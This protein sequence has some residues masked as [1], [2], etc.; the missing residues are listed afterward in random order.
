MGTMLELDITG[1]TRHEWKAD[2]PE[3]VATAREVYERL[4]KKG[5][6]GF[7]VGIDGDPGEQINS[8]DPELEE[9]IMMVPRV[10]GG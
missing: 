8:F 2:N 1:H 6:R 9:M 3:Q 7:K 4:R 10:V 5:Y